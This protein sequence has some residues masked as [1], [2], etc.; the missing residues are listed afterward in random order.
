MTKKITK[1]PGKWEVGA[2]I[3]ANYGNKGEYF[4][5]EITKVY[6]AMGLLKYYDLLYDDGDIEVKVKQ[7]LIRLLEKEIE[8]MVPVTMEVP[9]PTP[10]P[11]LAEVGVPLQSPP[12][13]HI[14]GVV[15]SGGTAW[16]VGDKV[17]VN[18]GNKGEYYPG[19]I[20]KV[21]G[22]V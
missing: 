1:I 7:S 6:P 20:D 12:P 17:E 8:E 5:G 4:K 13:A 3:E 22:L 15:G 21:G 14:G 11:G 16:R 18:Y 9:A 10:T 2:K 19:V